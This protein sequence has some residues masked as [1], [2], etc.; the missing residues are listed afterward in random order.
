[1][2][3]EVS[4]IIEWM[5]AVGDQTTMKN[6]RHFGVT[7]K[8]V[9]GIR[10]PQLMAKAREIGHGPNLG[11]GSLSAILLLEISRNGRSETTV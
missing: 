2:K 9:Y 11:G 6:V 7:A 8:N 10:I 4:D 3:Y 1:M 5:D